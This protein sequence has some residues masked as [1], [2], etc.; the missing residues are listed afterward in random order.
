MNTTTQHQLTVTITAGEVLRPVHPTLEGMSRPECLTLLQTGDI[1]RIAYRAADQ[2]IVVPVTFSLYDELIVFRTAEDSAIAQY[3][4]EPVAFEVD[5]IDE[6]MHE[7]WSVLVN[8]TVRPATDE[9]AA[10][11]RG[12]VEPWAGGTRDACMVIEPAQISGRRL[13]AW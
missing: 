5:R 2:L 6:G 13:R 9:E 12:R 7:G 8:G 3:A 1:G 10:E 11:V 4:L